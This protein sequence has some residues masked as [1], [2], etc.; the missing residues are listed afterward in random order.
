MYYKQEHEP[1][2][3]VL[4]FRDHQYQ[5]YL[6]QEKALN[7]KKDALFKKDVKE[8][9]YDGSMLELVGRRHDLKNDKRLAFPFILSKETSKLHEGR[10]RVNYFTNQ[11]L[12]ELR[13]V[14]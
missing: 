12:Y 13:R 5:K 6:L 2:L 8:W 14:G 3:E 10:E 11:I 7:E 4:K 1:M 9:K